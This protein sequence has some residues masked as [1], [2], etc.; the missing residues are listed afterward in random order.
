MTAL[1][2]GKSKISTSFLRRCF[3]VLT[4]EERMK[5]FRVAIAQIALGLLDLAAITAIGVLGA[6]GVTGIQSREPGDR[7]SRALELFGIADFRFQTQMAI[8]GSAAALIL[9]F[10]TLVSMALTRKILH[11]LSHRAANLSTRLV[12]NLLRRNI[13]E[14][15]Q[16]GTQE[17]LYALTSGVNILYL[18][19]VGTVVGLTADVFLAILLSLGL[20]VVDPIMSIGSFLLFAG[21]GFVLYAFVQK[22]AAQLGT[23]NAQLAIQSSELIMEVMGSYRELFVRNRRG[24]YSKRIGRTREILSSN[25]AEIAFMPNVGKY[26]IEIAM[27]VGAILI[28]AIQFLA[29]DATHAISTLTV[30]LAAASR[31]APAVLRIQTGA[32]T[33]KSNMGAV[34]PTLDLIQL[35]GTQSIEEIDLIHLNTNHAGFTA[36]LKVE[37]LEFKYPGN[38]KPTL[39]EISLQV[40][41]GSFVAVV[42]P[43]GAGK[44]TLIDLILGI[45]I[46]TNGRIEISGVSPDDAIKT[47]PGALSYVPQEINYS[48][49]TIFENVGFGYDRSEIDTELVEQ[50]LELAQLSNL[51][52]SLPDGIQSRIGE[53]AT[54]L[55]GGQRQR[56]GIARALYTK[57]K[58]LVLDE[59]TSSLDGQTELD[60]SDAIFNLKGQVTVVTIAHRLSTVRNADIV[61]YLENGKILAQGTFNEVR[62]IVPNFDAQAKL[63]GL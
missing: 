1:I 56:L 61:I 54:K 51:V 46:P 30:F 44:T 45:L 7:V 43:S 15:Q 5:V 58:L 19:I 28:S 10:R 38:Q 27:V 50:A 32:V 62:G 36:S 9:V 21:V 12:A 13:L 40:P 17:T 24:Y 41:A 3:Q 47:W 18:N 63:M 4:R 34:G 49:S 48:N 53:N 29:Q 23:E 11:F 14:I 39:Q 52:K 42:G 20:F 37:N 33:L 59:A 31:I 35:V 55:S 2:N 6:L 22:R 26:F 60:I 57:P 8:I 25:S 16:K